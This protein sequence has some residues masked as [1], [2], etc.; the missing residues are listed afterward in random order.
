MRSNSILIDEARTPLIISGPSDESSDLYRQVDE[1]MKV[2]VTDPDTY[3]KDEKQ[4]TVALTEPGA[5]RVEDMLR[6]A[7]VLTE[8]NLYDIFNVSLVH[9]AQQSLRAHTLYCTRCRLHRAQRRGHPDR[10]V[11]R[12]HDAS[13]G[14]SRRACIRRWRPR[15]TSPSSRKTRRWPRSR[16]RIISGCIRNSPA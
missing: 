7:G 1:V 13:A 8:G 11:H 5:E 12:P 16:S 9:H 4:R 14:G 3:E 2:L 15:N 10:R 6:E